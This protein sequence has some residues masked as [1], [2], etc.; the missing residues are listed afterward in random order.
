MFL[1]TWDHEGFSFYLLY[2][3]VHLFIHT[4]IMV[5]AGLTV[6]FSR[7]IAAKSQWHVCFSFSSY[8]VALEFKYLFRVSNSISAFVR[9]STKNVTYH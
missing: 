9:L 3:L 4:I 1:I 8:I 7:C 6:W 5:E 2:L